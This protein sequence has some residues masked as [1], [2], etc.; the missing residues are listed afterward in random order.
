MQAFAREC[1][2]NAPPGKLNAAAV[3]EAYLYHAFHEWDLRYLRRPAVLQDVQGAVARSV[4]HPGC[5]PM[6]SWVVACFDVPMSW[7]HIGRLWTNGEPHLAIDGDLR[8]HWHGYDDEV[9]ER[10]VTTLAA[11][12]V[13]IP[14]GSATAALLGDGVVRDDSWMEVF[15][16]TDG[17]IAIIQAGGSD[18]R[19]CV[20]AALSY[21]LDAD[22]LVADLEVP[23]GNIALFSSA[24]E[25]VGEGS[26]EL[27]APRPGEVPAEHGWPSPELDTGLLVPASSTLYQVRSRSYTKLD[28]GGCF[29]RW[30]LIPVMTD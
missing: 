22:D 4:G 29:A 3:V 25:G 17:R 12:P 8:Q 18:Y 15:T 1:A 27:I 28:E 14:V 24:C 5:R 6:Q 16:A 30:L 26:M 11:E 23:S 10:L 13:S 21:P 2:D 9:Y 7:T 20:A 19:T